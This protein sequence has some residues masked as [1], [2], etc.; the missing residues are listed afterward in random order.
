MFLRKHHFP[1]G[2][3]HLFHSGC[4]HAF[5]HFEVVEKGPPAK[6]IQIVPAKPRWNEGM[7]SQQ[8][9]RVDMG[10]KWQIFID[11]N[12]LVVY[13]SKLILKGHEFAN[14]LL[15]TTK[16]FC[17]LIN[18]QNRCIRLIQRKSTSYPDKPQNGRKIRISIKCLI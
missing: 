13:L 9:F 5:F 14:C 17:G 11:T 8:H 10:C 15:S 18:I 12:D 7:M 2:C 6:S 4:A 1:V 3:D 16:P